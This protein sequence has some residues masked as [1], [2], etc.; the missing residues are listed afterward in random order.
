MNSKKTLV[1]LHGWGL[2]SEIFRPIV[3]LLNNDFN[4]YSLDLP[5]FGKATIEKPLKLKDYAK[6][7]ENFN[8]AASLSTKEDGHYS[9]QIAYDSLGWAY[10][11]QGNYQ[12]A[13][14]SFNNALQ[15]HDVFKT[16]YIGMAFIYY[17][18]NRLE[19]SEAMINKALSVANEW[20]HT[21]IDPYLPQSF[22][23]CMKEK[24]YGQLKTTSFQGLDC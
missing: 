17:K 16:T 20:L 4:I 19:A 23:E 18:Q 10:L 6:A 5:G 8:K 21:H 2:T 12:N 9:I 1:F 11:R 3:G 24:D 13:L 14:E 22:V 7:I 15:E